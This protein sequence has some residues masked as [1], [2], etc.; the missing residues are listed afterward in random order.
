MSRRAPTLQVAG[1]LFGNNW[2]NYRHQSFAGR[3][4]VLIRCTHGEKQCC[5]ICGLRGR[6]TSCVD[7]MRRSVTA[8]VEFRRPIACLTNGGT[9]VGAGIAV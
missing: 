8:T 2:Q 5:S 6:S 4:P 1:R 9:L 7:G 3:P